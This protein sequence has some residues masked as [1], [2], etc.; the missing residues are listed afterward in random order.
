MRLALILMIK[1]ESKILERCLKAVENVVD[2]FCILDTGSTDNTVEIAQEFLKTHKGCVT[3]E[4]W[5]NFGHNRTISFQNA[6]KYIDEELKWDLK[7]TYGVLLDADMVFVP[8]TLRKQN[9]TAIGYRMIQVNGALEYYNTRL[10]RM[11]HPWKCVGVTHE[12]WDGGKDD[13][14]PKEVC[15]IDDK[16]DGG[17]KSDKYERDRRLL[18]K[19]LEDE[20]TNVRY[21]FYLAQ[22]LRCMNLHKEAI[23]MYKKRILA[24]GWVEEVWYSYYMIGEC[25]L[26]LNSQ[27]EF[28]DW[29]Q[30]AHAY[31]KTRAESL[32]KLCKTFRIIGQH[33][34]AYHYLQIGRSIPYP[35]DDVLFIEGDVYRGL[36][37]YE[38]SILEY[39]VHKENPRL[40]LESS[41][42]YLLKMG[43][44]TQNVIS[45]LHFYVK[46]IK[47]E[48]TPIILPSV[49]GEDFKPSAISVDNYPLANV[50]FVNYWIDNGEYKTKD[51]CPVMTEN[52]YMNIETGDCIAKMDDSSISL[53]RFNTHVKGLEDLR[54]YND[55]KFIAVSNREYKPNCVSLIQGT[56]DKTGKYEDVQVLKSPFNRG[57]E[58][59]WL[60]V[61][62]T[63]IFIYDWSPYTLCDI[64]GIILRQLQ[65]PPLFKI[66]RGS[67]PP[68]K[69]NDKYWC[70]V[71]FV[72]HSRPRKYYH[73][74]I[75]L[76]KALNPTRITLPFVFKSPSIEYCISA[77]PTDK[78]TID[79][80]VS[81]MDSNPCKVSISISDFEWISI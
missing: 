28:E 56:Y 48:I 55:N 60:P 42:K 27:T 52:A 40:G 24:G 78:N 36:F 12:Y 72:E 73:S 10:V 69:V 17:C 18:E 47:S 11:D 37:E 46:S 81:F 44:F 35:K 43:Q 19:G 13:S 75:E 76:D 30:R 39:Y 32:Y 5:Q 2:C 25:Y 8:G 80:F 41:I 26:N 22:T 50:R 14:L 59:N 68:F 65:T 16:N 64:N 21:M 63:N 74:V 62:G 20:P 33:Y 1:N 67:V 77:V 4:P 29:M 79:F 15:Y 58:K 53:P 57:C 66:F 71:H 9:L 3:V 51:S 70:L 7:D 23:E 6:R 49:F 34:K 31:R 54:L 61:S 38:A 45:N